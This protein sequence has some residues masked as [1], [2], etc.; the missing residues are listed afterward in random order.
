MDEFDPFEEISLDDF[1]TDEFKD[2][3]EKQIDPGD[4]GLGDLGDED[5]QINPD[6]VGLG[7]VVD[8]EGGEVDPVGDS[9]LGD[10]GSE[11]SSDINLESPEIDDNS[12]VEVAE[13]QLEINTP[14]WQVVPQD[15]NDIVS[16]HDDGYILRA[17][18][19]SAKQG[20]K[21]KYA[22]QITRDNKILDKGVIWIERDAN[23]VEFLQNVSDR[24]L[25]RFGY[26]KL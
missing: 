4:V 24:I 7:D 26:I 17:R 3:N 11:A 1:K 12:D 14:K 16:R 13:Q 6:D 21:V 9:A 5:G 2:T 19:L 22:A 23:P 18:L 8:E 20:S 15:N 10:I 25:S